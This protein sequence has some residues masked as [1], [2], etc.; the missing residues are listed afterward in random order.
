MCKKLICLISFVF[1][2]SL[3]GNALADLVADGRFG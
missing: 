2:L 3:A 1:T